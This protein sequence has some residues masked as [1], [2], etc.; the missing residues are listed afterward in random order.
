MNATLTIT[1]EIL[2]ES[3]TD[4]T[5]PRQAARKLEIV[6]RRLICETEQY[7]NDLR[8]LTWPRASRP[9]PPLAPAA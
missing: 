8:N 3:A 1:C 9:T 2:K 4:S 5:T 6:R 7:L